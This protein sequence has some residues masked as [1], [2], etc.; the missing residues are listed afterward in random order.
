L[1]GG[2][3]FRGT[4]GGFDPGDPRSLFITLDGILNSTLSVEDWNRELRMME[5]HA[6]YISGFFDELRQAGRDA[7]AAK[8]KKGGCKK[9]EARDKWIYD[10]CCEDDPRLTHEA[11]RIQLNRIC[12]EKGWESVG[13]NNAIRQAAIRYAKAKGIGPPPSRQE[14]SE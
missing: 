5:V 3:E 4:H 9:Q 1:T 6:K 7:L 13:T 14:P 10:K 8:R 12:K 2:D 11:I